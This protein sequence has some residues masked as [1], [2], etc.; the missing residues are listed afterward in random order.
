M[1]ASIEEK[2][3]V[4]EKLPVG[5]VGGDPNA[6]FGGT[7]ARKVLEKK[8][9]LKLDLRMSI[10]VVIYIL[11]YVRTFSLRAIRTCRPFTS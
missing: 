11:N 3:I 9:L 6:E 7:E 1:S 2:V 5:Y 10:M 8:L 4:E